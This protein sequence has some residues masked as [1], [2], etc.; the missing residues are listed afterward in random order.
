[1]EDEA[2]PATKEPIFCSRGYCGSGFI[3]Q[4]GLS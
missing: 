2:L 3:S 1:M 4:A